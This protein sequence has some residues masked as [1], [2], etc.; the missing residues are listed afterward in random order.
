MLLVAETIYSCYN[1]ENAHIF[2]IFILLVTFCLQPLHVR[3]IDTKFWK[4]L[5]YSEEIMYLLMK[6]IT[7]FNNTCI[8]NLQ[9]VCILIYIYRTCYI[10]VL[11]IQINTCPFFISI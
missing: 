1:C 7:L 4:Q 3:A 6:F 11:I 5:P 9:L 8:R 10:V 2:C